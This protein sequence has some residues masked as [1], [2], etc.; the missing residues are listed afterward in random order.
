MIVGIAWMQDGYM[1]E[2]PD[3]TGVGDH[4][5]DLGIEYLVGDTA[6][7]AQAA[8]SDLNNLVG[9]APPSQHDARDVDE[10][11]G[12]DEN[13]TGAFVPSVGIL[14]TIGLLGASALSQ[15]RDE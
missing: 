3:I 5:V 7:A 10:L 13:E 14:A 6:R 12:T 4:T 2:G 11:L 8:A 9:L 1:L 15:R